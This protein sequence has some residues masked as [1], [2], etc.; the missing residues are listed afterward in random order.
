MFVVQLAVYLPVVGVA[1]AVLSALLMV[2]DSLLA[3]EL[4]AQG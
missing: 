2:Q 4:V 3:L 1:T